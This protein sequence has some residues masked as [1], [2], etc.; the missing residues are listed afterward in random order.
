MDKAEQQL[1]TGILELKKIFFE[2]QIKPIKLIGR[3]KDKKSVRSKSMSMHKGS[4]PNKINLS[5]SIGM[6]AIFKTDTDL[7]KAYN[8]IIKK[9]HIIYIKDYVN[10]PRRDGLILKTDPSEVYQS[11]HIFTDSLNGTLTEV[12]LRTLKMEKHRLRL[13]NKYGDGYWKTKEFRKL[14][15]M[16]GDKR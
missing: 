16:L 11:Y 3:V 4:I 1:K 5:D 10:N 2:L 7:N 9:E 6:R 13:K 14:K 15:Y 12:Q 8:G